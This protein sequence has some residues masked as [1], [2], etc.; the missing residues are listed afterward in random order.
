MDD[1]EDFFARTGAVLATMNTFHMIP[2]S[3]VCR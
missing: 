1:T 3:Q 2:E